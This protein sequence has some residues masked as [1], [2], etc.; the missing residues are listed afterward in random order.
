MRCRINLLTVL[1]VFSI[2]ISF[3]QYHPDGCYLEGD[4]SLESRSNNLDIL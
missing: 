3:G 4:V 1:A 2:G